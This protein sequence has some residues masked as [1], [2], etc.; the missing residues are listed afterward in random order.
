LSDDQMV[1]RPALVGFRDDFIE[2]TLVNILP[3]NE[4]Q[5]D[6]GVGQRAGIP[7]NSTSTPTPTLMPDSARRPRRNASD[8]FGS[9]FGSKS[10]S[11][12]ESISDCAKSI[13]S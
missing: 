10:A 8:N 6:L 9:Q 3:R 7:P 12:K 13:S 5:F 2:N 1:L 11:R 4:A